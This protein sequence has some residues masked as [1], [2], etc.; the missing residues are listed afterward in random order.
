MCKAVGSN[1]KPLDLALVFQDL[2][3]CTAEEA[4]VLMSPKRRGMGTITSSGA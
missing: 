3:C 4:D 1:G 2:Q